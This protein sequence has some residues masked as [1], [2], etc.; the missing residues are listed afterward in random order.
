MVFSLLA[1]VADD[2]AGDV[3][4]WGPR[5]YWGEPI[6]ICALQNAAW[7]HSLQGLR[8]AVAREK[9]PGRLAVSCC[10]SA[11][12]GDGNTYKKRPELFTPGDLGSV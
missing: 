4:A 7:A 2:G 8:V 1:G 11:R 12:P 3:D 5:C 9:I 6:E 10:N